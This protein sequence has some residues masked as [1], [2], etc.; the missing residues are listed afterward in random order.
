MEFAEGQLRPRFF[1]KELETLSRDEIKRIQLKGVQA[2]LTRL[3]HASEFY[4]QRLDAARVELEEITSLE[5]F[6]EKVPFLTKQ[7][8]IQDQA[9]NPPYGSRL[10][11]SPRE[12]RQI[13][14][15]SG[16]SGMGQEIHALTEEDVRCNPESLC[17][18]FTAVGIE[19]GDLCALLWPVASMAGGQMAW[20][21]YQLMGA[22]PLSIGVYD[23]Q[24]KL[25]LFKQFSPHHIYTTPAYLTRLTLLG[26]EVD[27]VP[28]RDCS[29]LKGISV[30]NEAFPVEWALRMEEKW[31]TVMHETYGSAQL[32]NCFATCERG[33]VPNGKRGALHVLEHLVLVETLDPKTG[34]QVTY[35][36]EGEPVITTFSR[37]GCPSVRFRTGDRVRLM[38]PESCGCGRTMDCWESGTIARYDDMIKMRGVNIWP[39]AVDEAVF[40]YAEVD[41]Y[42]GK[43]Y[44]DEEGRERVV[45]QVEFTKQLDDAALKGRIVAKL[46]EALKAKTGISMEVQAVPHGTVQRFEY[47]GKRW[48]DER[49]KGLEKA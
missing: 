44:L 4:R 34:K 38:P 20:R 16:T 3:Y 35:G 27:F 46:V 8:L 5:A 14:T 1:N 47:K 30:A 41:E 48:V 36:E 18:H 12:V 15:T 40:S 13:H 23:A 6:A 42:N 11:V 28:K 17:Y 21:M 10:P 37:Q 2:L 39:M 49:I 22:V 43:V 32:G 7:D 31:G 19:P 29:R 25:R 24:T 9:Q 45:L 33:A 26:E